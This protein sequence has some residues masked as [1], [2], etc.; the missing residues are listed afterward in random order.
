MP[1]PARCPAPTAAGSALPAAAC[2]VGP[3]ALQP[4]R[5]VLRLAGPLSCAC[6][7]LVRAP[8]PGVPQPIAPHRPQL[9]ARRSQ[10]VQPAAA[11]NAPAPARGAALAWSVL[12]NCAKVARFQS[13]CGGPPKDLEISLILSDPSV[14]K[15]ITQETGA[16]RHLA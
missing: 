8:G 13:R 4:I 6:R 5:Q 12:L 1:A 9:A 15:E 2:S 10:P 7:S 14:S 16:P 3:S 11:R